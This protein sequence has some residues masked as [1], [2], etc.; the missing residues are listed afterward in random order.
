VNGERF[1]VLS[2]DE[3]HIADAA[4]GEVK[5]RRFPNDNDGELLDPNSPWCRIWRR[6]PQWRS[7]AHSPMQS[8]GQ[9][10]NDL[11]LL[12][13]GIRSAAESRLNA[14][15]FMLPQEILLEDGI[16]QPD[17]GDGNVRRDPFMADLEAA[18]LEPI[19]DPEHPSARVPLLLRLPNEYIEKVKHMLLTRPM[20]E[21][22]LAE[23]DELRTTLATGLDI[24]NEILLGMSDANHWTAWQVDEQ[25]FKAHLEPLAVLMTSGIFRG[26]LRPA[27]AAQ[28]FLT[29]QICIGYDAT[30]LIGDEDLFDRYTQMHDARVV[31]HAAYRRAGGASEDDAPDQEELDTWPVDNLNETVRVADQPPIEAPSET[32]APAG[33]GQDAAQAASATPGT[34][35][36]V[37]AAGIAR[38]KRNADLGRLASRLQTIDRALRLRVGEKAD[39]AVGRALEIA[40]AKARRAV[41]RDAALAASIKSMRNKE[42]LAFIGKKRLATSFD[43]PRDDLADDDTF[44]DL[45]LAFTALSLRAYRQTLAAI[46]REMHSDLTQ[47]AIDAF[48]V[49]AARNVASGLDVL[50]TAVREAI[51]ER[52]FS[53]VGTAPA[54][55]EFDGLAFVRAGAV[56]ESL[57][58]AGGAVSVEPDSITQAPSGGIAT[59]DATTDMME[60]TFGITVN[61]GRWLYGDPS[62]RTRT[63]EPHELLDGV[64]FAS[65]D[66]DVLA[67]TEDWPDTPFFFPGDHDTCQCDYLPAL[68][69][70]E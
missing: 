38:P 24:P 41:Q 68:E 57:A 4:R 56:R 9:T 25:T 63:F 1:D 59:G 34:L 36:L 40:G 27:L 10:C 61:G 39:H 3:L 19:A 18:M 45:G 58:V 37:T 30:D 66:D 17:D 70:G 16:D 12:R 2:I 33:N 44:D 65:W 60:S 29:N 54:K 50:T 23:R 32:G 67:N 42:I 43:F 69:A 15:I 46:Y 31:S 64:D 6:H 26:F 48:E 35:A 55:G 7:Y 20:D 21:H 22:E 8:L 51:H 11:L 28:Q 14:G 5:I 53:P 47:S 52:L 13:R 49:D 62:S